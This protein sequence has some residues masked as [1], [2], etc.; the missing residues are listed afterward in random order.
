MINDLD[1]W[2]VD[3]PNK[4]ESGTDLLGGRPTV[5]WALALEN[6]DKKDRSRL[7]SLLEESLPDE[8]R[9]ARALELYERADVYRRA[10]SLISKHHGRAREAADRFE[11][12]PLRRLLHFLADAILDRRPLAVNEELGTRN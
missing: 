7:E 1:D 6:L 5:L 12:E 9:I 10:T 2:Q 4:R 8:T 11:E 3:Q